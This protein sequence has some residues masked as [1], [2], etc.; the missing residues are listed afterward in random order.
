V[1]RLGTQSGA[2]LK[3]G[4][5]ALCGSPW[6]EVPYE[7]QVVMT[8]MRKSLKIACAAAVLFLAL[9]AVVLVYTGV[10][11]DS[12]LA[13]AQQNDNREIQTFFNTNDVI[14]PSNM[15]WPGR[16]GW[17]HDQQMMREGFQMGQLLSENATLSTVQGTVVTQ[18]GRVLILDTGSGQ[19]RVMVPN[20]WIVGS[21]VIK[22]TA[23][24]NGTFV[25]SGQTLT[26]KVLES[27]LFS[28]AN[29]S[30]N[31][32]LGYEAVNATG[33]HAYAVLP[34]NIQPKS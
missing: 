25:S 33:T 24:F 12:A 7:V 19:V 8:N 32:M 17:C 26:V 13:N 6:N 3:N 20:E 22:S 10:Q 29:F 21:E 30:L 23:L 16:M 5:I 1:A 9:G 18:S 2:I 15:S 14:L 27:D 28:N 34:F 11:S 31:L 4:I